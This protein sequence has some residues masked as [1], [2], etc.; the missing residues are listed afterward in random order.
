MDK[1]RNWIFKTITNFIHTK[2]HLENE[3]NLVNRENRAL[4]NRALVNREIEHLESE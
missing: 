4:D 3:Q 1:K 2:N